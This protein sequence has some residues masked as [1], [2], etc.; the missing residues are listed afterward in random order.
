MAT[1]SNVV[2]KVNC[3]HLQSSASTLIN[4]VGTTFAD[5]TMKAGQTSSL[6]DPFDA[7][8][9]AAL[10]AM[11]GDLQTLWTDVNDLATALST[12]ADANPGVDDTNASNMTYSG[13]GRRAA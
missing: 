7:P 11:A 5:A 1:I 4:S 8:Y 2:L 10:G 13:P 9:N 3:F 12:A 6:G